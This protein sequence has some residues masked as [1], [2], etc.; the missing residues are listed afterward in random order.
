VAVETIDIQISENG[1]R[2]VKRNFADLASQSLDTASAV[3]TLKGALL[4]LSIAAAIRQVITLADAFTTLQNK[5]AGAGVE[6]RALTTITNEL[7]TVADATRASVEATGAIF[8]RLALSAKETGSSYQQLL[9]ITKSLNQAL[10]LSGATGHEAA[11][12]LLQLSQ[13]IASNR[14]GGDELR[15]ILEQLPVVADVIAKH[16]KVTRG[17]L[18][19]LGTAGKLTA[20]VVLDAFKEARDELNERF[21]R[22][23]P[24]ISQAFNVLHNDLLFFIGNLDKSN[25][26]TRALASAMITLGT[27]IEG[28][29]KS[30]LVLSAALAVLTGASG[31]G[32]IARI[33]AAIAAINPFVLLLAALASLAAA[34]VLFGDD[35]KIAGDNLTTLTDLTNQF[36]GEA[37]RGFDDL[38]PTARDYFNVFVTDAKAKLQELTLEHGSVFAAMS[39]TVAAF[40]KD[41]GDIIRD[42]IVN[43]AREIDGIRGA[44]AVAIGVIQKLWG[45][46]LPIL[47]TAWKNFT[48]VIVT[49]WDIV[50][51]SIQEA[52]VNS[53]I[54]ITKSWDSLKTVV[55]DFVDTAIRFIG[56]WAV[57]IADHIG[58]VLPASIK[59]FFSDV[60][61]WVVTLFK[62]LLGVVGRVV[63][64]IRALFEKGAV[65]VASID[66]PTSFGI[67]PTQITADSKAAI[68]KLKVY[69]SEIG[70]VA[71]T[72]LEK[73]GNPVEAWVNKSIEEAKTAAKNRKDFND[74]FFPAKVDLNK[75][76]PDLTKPL[77][78]KGGKG[79]ESLAKQILELEKRINP[80]REAM[81]EYEKNLL[82]IEKAHKAGIL[83]LA[84]Y[85]ELLQANRDHLRENVDES[86]K[87]Q[88]EFKAMLSTF[89]D[90]MKINP[91]FTADDAR[92][93][94][95]KKKPD[96]FF[97]TDE[98]IRTK[99]R[100][101]Q[102]AQQQ[103]T[104]LQQT[105]WYTEQQINTMRLVQLGLLKNAVIQAGLAMIQVK[106][107]SGAG[108][109]ADVWLAALGKVQ[110]GFTTFASG[111]SDILG[112]FYTNLT[113]GFANSIG[114]AIVY[115]EDLGD[116][117]YKVAQ[118]ALSD[119]ISGFIK[120]GIQWIV[121]QAIGQSLAAASTA[122]SVAMGAT[123]AAAWAP[124][125][126]AVS[127]ATFGANSGPAIAGM[128]AAAAAQAGMGILGS[129][130]S[131]TL[132]ASGGYTGNM[133]RNQIAGAVH[134]QEFVMNAAAT[135]RIGVPTLEAMQAGRVAPMR[136]N[137]NPRSNSRPV[138]VQIQ[139]F[140]VSKDFEVQ[141][142]TPDDVRIIARDEAKKGVYAHAPHA[143]ASDITNPNGRVSKALK[144][145]TL[146]ER[147]RSS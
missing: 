64:A 66:A 14:L 67:D 92:A 142:I 21:A 25:G 62:D 17:E 74:M 19:A 31:L 127:L 120:L 111:T 112:S 75:G 76:G 85:N 34:V 96:L 5:L 54:F 101:Y 71:R 22:T 77:A 130:G 110:Q 53:T 136:A 29:A 55:S 60:Y 139:N 80:A 11:A 129:L 15:S 26:F 36:T 1:S 4:G 41:S 140:G 138:N 82:L 79:L 24:T 119:L 20:K 141:Q 102:I 48:D 3:D 90:V 70:N 13:A 106:L 135:R 61:N 57:A 94:V 47:E 97:G 51:Q 108:D 86:F 107:Q 69:W 146:T 113:D 9:D 7:L 84:K 126:L 40:S 121:N 114:R 73:S 115:S 122:A 144:N 68:E 32:L 58:N 83:P 147:R 59:G 72:E 27:N 42:F 65:G 117:L 28:V 131:G 104:M 49:T 56:A 2:T 125:A 52:W 118:G 137:D 6:A 99:V 145:N 10:I 133:A 81:A 63:N 105:G 8:S 16:L 39:G 98:E 128:A 33:L 88:R 30:V 91:Q 103:I 123:V 87:A 143:V 38:Q 45:D 134:G 23:I 132:F 43:T 37:K 93:Q 35:I 12:G 109:W 78:G 116:A 46:L 18:R 100:E 50:T 89:G 124:A 95:A 44:W